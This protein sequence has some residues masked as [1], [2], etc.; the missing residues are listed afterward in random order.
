LQTEKEKGGWAS[1]GV[2]RSEVKWNGPQEEKGKKRKRG[3][4]LAEDFSP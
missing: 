1:D 2:G 3:A 4:G